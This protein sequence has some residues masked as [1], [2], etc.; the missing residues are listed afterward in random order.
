MGRQVTVGQLLTLVA[1][2]ISQAYEFVI[3]SGIGFALDSLSS[4]FN[5]KLTIYML[6][7]EHKQ[8]VVGT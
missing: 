3:M 8:Y 2:T 1:L 5:R 4:I 6:L 7:T